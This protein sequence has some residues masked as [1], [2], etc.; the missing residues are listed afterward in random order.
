[1]DRQLIVIIF[2]VLLIFGCNKK[3]LEN[4]TSTTCEC[5]GGK[6]CN[7]WC[8]LNEDNNCTPK[9]PANPSRNKAMVKASTGYY[10]DAEETKPK[11][12]TWCDYFDYDN[13]YDRKKAVVQDDES[14]SAMDEYKTFANN[15]KNELTD[16]DSDVA[17]IIDANVAVID[18]YNI[19][20]NENKTSTER[21][22]ACKAVIDS[23]KNFKYPDPNKSTQK[24]L[25]E[26]LCS[27]GYSVD[28]T[29]YDNCVTDKDLAKCNEI[30]KYC[31]Q[32]DDF[33]EIDDVKA[34][35]CDESYD[36]NKPEYNKCIENGDLNACY[37]LIKTC[38][39][40]FSDDE[41][42]VNNDAIFKI[43]DKLKEIVNVT[44]EN[45]NNF[46]FNRK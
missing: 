1:M 24:I 6:T 16:A 37:N 2:I 38:G 21:L 18:N 44:L 19:C 5:E 39:S 45:T 28:T 15:F 13:D 12:W 23:G 10:Y 40:H 31:S 35:I 27:V 25:N 8:Y 46:N 14:I 9:F 20:K 43:E 34:T 26:D 22:T 42:K 11:D 29:K 17:T 7:D 41:N 3:P 32:A 30:L 4:F 36:L 33:K